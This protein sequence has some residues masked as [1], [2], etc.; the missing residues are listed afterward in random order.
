MVTS[1]SLFLWAVHYLTLG[2][3][4][5]LFLKYLLSSSLQRKRAKFYLF[6]TVLGFC[7]CAG[8]YLVAAS[9]RYSLVAECGLLIAGASLVAE[10]RLLG[11]WTSV[12]VVPGL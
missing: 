12:A 2:D 8:F 11:T 6:L 9:R 5:S 7:C 4:L 10:Y 1:F 3:S